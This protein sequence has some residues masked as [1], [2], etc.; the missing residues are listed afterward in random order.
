[1]HDPGW[2]YLPRHRHLYLHVLEVGPGLGVTAGGWWVGADSHRPR[3]APPPPL[4][5]TDAGGGDSQWKRPVCPGRAPANRVG[6]QAGVQIGGPRCLRTLSSKR[7]CRASEPRGPHC[8]LHRAQEHGRR[9]P[10]DLLRAHG[11][12][13]C[14]PKAPGPV[15]WGDRYTL[16]WGRASASI[17]QQVPVV[18][19]ALQNLLTLDSS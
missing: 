19:A 11:Q 5:S 2:R 14:V 17:A 16:I 3:P 1:M 15:G 9:D 8:P 10:Q 13:C 7:A 4:V 18:G 12:P 6:S